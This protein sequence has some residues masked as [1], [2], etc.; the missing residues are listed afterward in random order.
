[1]LLSM[2]FWGLESCPIILE[3]LKEHIY[4]LISGK[5]SFLTAL[6]ST[7]D[8][9][10]NAKMVG[11]FNLGSPGLIIRD[12]ELVKLIMVK[13]FDHFVDRRKL[14]VSPTSRVSGTIRH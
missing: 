10:P 5:S 8:N 2:L 14:E 3:K 11:V 9:N 12:I 4:I 6:N 13:D 1:M 7:Y